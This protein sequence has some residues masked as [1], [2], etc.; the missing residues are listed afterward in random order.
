MSE[1][2]LINKEYTNKAGAKGVVIDVITPSNP[3]SVKKYTTMVKIAFE[4]GYVGWYDIRNV[5]KGIFK[6]YGT[7]NSVG[8]YVYKRDINESNERVYNLWNHMMNRC[9]NENDG[10]YYSYG[11]RGVTVCERWHYLKNFEEDIKKLENYDIWLT[12]EAYSLDKDSKVKGNLEYCKEKCIFTDRKTQSLNRISVKGIR[13]IKVSDGTKKIYK[14][15]TEASLDT[16]VE[17][18]NIYKVLRG[19]IRQS[20]GFIFE[21]I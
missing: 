12:D 1:S 5:R 2:K 14:S 13:S 21:Y 17:R 20:G 15:Q 11:N 16:G 7:P 8:G 6:D 3:I 18:S 10:K 4:S 9:Y 19:H